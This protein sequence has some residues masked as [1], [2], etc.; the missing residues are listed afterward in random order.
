MNTVKI[1]TTQNVEV[2]YP[3]ASVGDRIVATIIDGAVFVVWF[4]AMAVA[5]QFS[6]FVNE[7][8]YFVL[9]M[10]P[11]MFY[12]L[13]FEIFMNGQSIGKKARD[14]KVVKLSGEAPSVGDYLLRWL[15]RLV[16]MGISSGLV[17]VITVAASS[18]GQRLGDMAAGTCVIR[19]RA[20]QRRA[21]LMMKTE[22][23]YQ[24]VFPEVS[25]LNDQDL[26]QIRKLAYKAKQHQNYELLEKTALRVKEV[27]GIQT[28]LS[29][30]E[31][32]KTVAKDYHHYTHGEIEVR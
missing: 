18:K 10:L 23:N 9:L 27:T 17:A 2:E 4:M 22:E 11:P 12:H 26:V 14:I 1:Q 30:W 7:V 8:V 32:L 6:N 21:P 5:F 31:F 25:Q 28:D 3:L 29:D 20:V 15:F 16:D 24:I 19:T 13:L